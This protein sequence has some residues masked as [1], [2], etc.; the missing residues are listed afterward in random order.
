MAKANLALT[1]EQIDDAARARLAARQARDTPDAPE[2]ARAQA[3]AVLDRLGDEPGDLHTVL[4][5]EPAPAWPAIVRDELTRWADLDPAERRAELDAWIDGQLAHGGRGPDLAEA[6]L[7]MLIELPPAAMQEIIRSCVDALG[8]REEDVQERFRFQ[9]ARAMPRFPVPQF[10][11]LGDMFN[12]IA[13][14][15]GQKAAW[16]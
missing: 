4:D 11:R 8:R 5:H 9:V 14:E 1:F 10:L 15:L 7:G 6:W 2:P 3:L 16:R 12:T 13:E